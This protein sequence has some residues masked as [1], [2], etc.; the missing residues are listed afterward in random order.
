MSRGNLPITRR[1]SGYGRETS[2]AHCREKTEKHGNDFRVYIICCRCGQRID[3]L[4]S[5][6]FSFIP[7]RGLLRISR[8]EKSLRIEEMRDP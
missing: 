8:I 2:V 7:R 4:N 1:F 3:E 6:Y 5:S